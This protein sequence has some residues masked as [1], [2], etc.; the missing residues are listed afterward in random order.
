[1]TTAKKI[2]GCSSTTSNTVLRA[3]LG[4]YPLETI[5][6]VRKL[7]WQY[8]VNNMPEKRLPAIVD[9]S[10]WEGR[11][12]IRWDNAVEKI[13]KDTGGGQEEV[14]SAEIFGGYKTAVKERIEERER[15]TLRNTAKEKEH[16]DI[17]GGLR[18]DIRMKTYLHGPMDYAKKLKLPF[19]VGDLDLP[20]RRKRCISSQ[21]E[22]DVA[23]NM[24]PCY[25]AQQWKVGL[26]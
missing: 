4:M 12:G 2:L 20:E 18:E 26:T 8:K 6:D 15:Q 19:R 7:K 13:W 10:V 24:C 21:E 3:E 1:M 16:L 23:T 14:V 22:E 5:R 9:N 25:V 17:H 11:A